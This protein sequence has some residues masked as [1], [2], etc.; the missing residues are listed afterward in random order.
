MLLLLCAAAAPRANGAIEVTPTARALQPGELVVLT[1]TTP[2]GVDRVSVAAFGRDIPAVPTGE[3][4][5]RALVG[6]DVAAAPGSYDVSI[7]ASAGEESILASHAL[8]IAGVEFPVRELSVDGAF[9][10]PPRAA[11]ARIRREAAALANVWRTSAPEPLW[12]G[13]FVRPVPGELISSFGKRSVFNG[14]P[15]GVHS[16]ADFRGPAGTPVQAPNAGRVA[17]ARDLYY[18]GNTVIIDH[19][20]GLFSLFAHLSK[21]TVAEGQAVAIGQ[22]VGKVGATGR[23]TG[24]HLHWAVRI[25]GARV[26]PMSLLALLGSEPQTYV[27]A[28][29]AAGSMF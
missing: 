4:T 28:T 10:N 13:A 2:P 24:P 27:A 1:F 21:L 23:V 14:E 25:N 17:L 3:N 7:D 19:G 6:I 29:P 5:W 26:D 20:L 12:S 22:T 16:G 11:R 18:T 9:V 15:R 8:E